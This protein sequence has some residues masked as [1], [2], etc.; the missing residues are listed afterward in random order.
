VTSLA[1]WVGVDNR[2]TSS[3]YFASDSRITWHRSRTKWNFGK[4]LF[5]SRTSSDVFGY[6]GDVLFPVLFLGQLQSLLDSSALF[7]GTETPFRR[8]QLVAKMV[9]DSL[10]TYPDDERSDFVILHGARRGRSLK[11][12]F[13]IWQLQWSKTDGWKDLEIRLPNESR[14]ALALGSGA[15]ELKRWE[16]EWQR[17]LGGVSRA[18]FGAFCDALQ[19]GADPKTSGAPQ[20][21]RLYRDGPGLV[22][23]IIVGKCTTPTSTMVRPE[24]GYIPRRKINPDAEYLKKRMPRV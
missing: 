22:V 12:E 15:D 10:D 18:V 21:V 5:A 16:A 19:E 17:P 7:D 23:G 2:G 8:H 20:L 4:K 14:L 3:L 6:C 13:H 11:S 9:Q 24:S 1:A